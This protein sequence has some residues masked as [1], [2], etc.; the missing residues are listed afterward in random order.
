MDEYRQ[1]LGDALERA[2]QKSRSK[3]ADVLHTSDLSREDRE[4]LVSSGWLQEVTRGWY[5]L[6][7][8]D[9]APGDSTAWYAHFWEFLRIY[10]EHHYD[11]G[12]CLSAESSLQL[13]L[14]EMTIPNQVI[15]IV[16]KG[17]GKL[18]EL[19]HDTSVYVYADEKNLPPEEDQ[20][21]VHGLRCMSLPLALCRV[22]PRFFL[23]SPINAEIALSTMEQPLNL[24]HTAARYGL[25]QAVGRLIGGY[26]H[27]G[28]E[29]IA[30]SLRSA[31]KRYRLRF[32]EANPFADQSPLSIPVLTP[33]PY[34]ARV[35][36]LWAMHR[37]AVIQNFPE[38]PPRLPD[39]KSYLHNMEGVYVHD[40][41]NSLSIEGY[42]VSPDLV[43]QVKNDL[44]DPDAHP[45]DAM[46]RNALAARGYYEAFQE[47]KQSVSAVLGD[48]SPGEI[49][50]ANLHSW[51]TQL[52]SSSVEAGLISSRDLAGY[53]RGPVYIRGSR[54]VPPPREALLDAMG[55]F[56]DCL[57]NE[58]HPAVRAILGHYIF[59][60]IHPY[61][62]GN[63][64]TARFLMNT[65]LASGGYPWT[66]IRVARRNEYI[67][68]L[69]NTTIN[70][71]IGPFAK[72]VAE[73]LEASKNL[74]G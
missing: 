13:H 66:V 68:A 61:P 7:R 1:R 51:Y 70:Q 6:V 11:K 74:S 8:P 34:G 20:E 36:A 35:R 38:P 16:H 54:H 26:V 71:D 69:E 3:E 48:A 9:V 39:K 33:S 27:I 32:T 42:R 17:G 49:A 67:A 65:M 25:H 43:E 31:A 2:K 44:W 24:I 73:E 50:R 28:Q 63:G 22:G 30:D 56:F 59:V 40:A 57:Q 60:Y 12:Y 23:D 58:E 19:P 29:T 14:G 62:D 37:D 64:R 5:L 52:F 4:L 45:K 41:Y 53:R 46:E 10:L 15:A 72:F 55:A 18:R 47:V 21:R